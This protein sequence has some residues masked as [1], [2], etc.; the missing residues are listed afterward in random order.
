MKVTGTQQVQIDLCDK[1]AKRLVV[2]YLC[3]YFDWKVGYFLEDDYIKERVKYTT[4][5][6]WTETET[7]R[8]ATQTDKHLYTIFKELSH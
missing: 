2:E 8:K 6:T 1:E 3:K 7:V 5:H 4:S